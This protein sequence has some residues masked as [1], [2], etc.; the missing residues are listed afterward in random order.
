MEK[1]SIENNDELVAESGV[2]DNDAVG[3]P[4]AAGSTRRA[5]YQPPQTT[6]GGWIVLACVTVLFFFVIQ[7]FFFKG[8]RI[9][10]NSMYPTLYVG[11]HILVNKLVYGY[12]LF[13]TN[14]RIF[15]MQ[16]PTFGD[17]VVFGVSSNGERSERYLVKRIVGMPGDLV[18]L[19]NDRTFINGYEVPEGEYIK[20]AEV[21]DAKRA[22]PGNYG[23][24]KLGVEEYFVLGDNRAHSQDS[25]VFG[26]I[27]I[28]DIQGK[29]FMVYWSW[30]LDENG[31][32]TQRW[33]RIGRRVG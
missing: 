29:A 1:E 12:Q 23:P 4:G 26:P 11:D 10:S 33:S 28:N 31:E 32:L 15:Q 6:I 18:E 24:I 30:E 19:R 21:E 25:R 20:I 2:E 9:P 5:G 16:L 17:V 7:E 27:T 8:Y 13:G 3:E 14:K 22:T